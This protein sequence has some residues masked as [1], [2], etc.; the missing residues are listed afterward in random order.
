[1]KHNANSLIFIIVQVLKK[2]YVTSGYCCIQLFMNSTTQE[3][4]VRHLEHAK[5]SSQ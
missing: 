3:D 2:D 4:A 5:V 1:V